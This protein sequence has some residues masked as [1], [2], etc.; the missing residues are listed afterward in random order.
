MRVANRLDDAR[1]KRIIASNFN[2]FFFN[3]FKL[4]YFTNGG[5]R[6]IAR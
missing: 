5:M 4:S 3:L 1:D 2:A 6:S